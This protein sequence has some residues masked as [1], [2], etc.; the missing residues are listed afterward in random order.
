MSARAPLR[1]S[2]QNSAHREKLCAWTIFYSKCLCFGYWMDAALLLSW[3]CFELISQ[4]ELLLSQ[5]MVTSESIE[6]QMELT[7]K[8]M[9]QTGFCLNQRTGK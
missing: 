9:T 4:K 5:M 8:M 1:T 6:R 7:R 3:G 2:P